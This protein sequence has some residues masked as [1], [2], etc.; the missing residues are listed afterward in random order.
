MAFPDKQHTSLS[1][2]LKISD[3]EVHVWT[4][5]LDYREESF[6]PYLGILDSEELHISASFRFER[7]RQRFIIRRIILRK[8]L[9][10]YLGITPQM[11]RLRYSPHGKPYLLTPCDGDSIQ[12]NTSHSKGLALY[13]FSRQR[14]LGVDLESLQLI[15]EID[16]LLSRWLPT[17]EAV[18]LLKLSTEKKHLAFFTFWVQKEAYLKALGQGLSHLNDITV[19]FPVTPEFAVQVSSGSPFWVGSWSCQILTPAPN[20]VAALT[21]EGGDYRLRCF[22]WDTG[23]D[24]QSN[25]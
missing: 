16:A 17:Q 21:V 4:V 22:K 23:T 20:Y 12:F 3:L 2:Q 1:E 7:D 6:Y 14:H 11:V 24:I 8:L 9:S 25:L 10:L 19:F 13:V 5:P 18:S 15:P